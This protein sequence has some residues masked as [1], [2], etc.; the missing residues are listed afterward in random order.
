MD[1]R[2]R[3]QERRLSAGADA[4]A[5]EAALLA[6]DLRAGRVT[7]AQVELAAAVGWPAARAVLGKKAP[8]LPK[9]GS[10]PSGSSWLRRLGE[11]D[12][13]LLMRVQVALARGRSTAET[14]AEAVRFLDEVEAWLIFGGPEPT[15]VVRLR[16]DP[17]A[18]RNLAAAQAVAT[19]RRGR[20]PALD[21]A[22]LRAV[23]DEVGPW[24]LGRGDPVA[25]RVAARTPPP[26]PTPPTYPINHHKAFIRAHGGPRSLEDIDD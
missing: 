1:Q 25:A 18:V 10:R 14:P 4:A 26:P 13:R 15:A 11:Y 8:A 19:A 22:D 17:D 7:P 23:R 24:A 3:E 20:G 2:R 21:E 6:D 5:A 9:L 12:E 16:A